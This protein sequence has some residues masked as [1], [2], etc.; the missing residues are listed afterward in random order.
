MT[1]VGAPGARAGPRPAARRGILGT[2]AS[3]DH[4]TL[5]A[6]LFTTA[7]GFFLAAGVL[8]LLMRFELARPRL[9]LLT[10]HGYDELFTLHGST[11]IY[12]FATPI[13]LGA[14]R[15]PRAAADR[16]RAAEVAAAR[17]R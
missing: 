9:Q 8:A 17:A 5:G 14:R 16:R 1:A 10:L 4:K 13:A 7:F 12:L 3:T 11:M 15:L 2:L 6:G